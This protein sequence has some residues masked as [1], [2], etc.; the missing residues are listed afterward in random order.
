[1]EFAFEADEPFV[2]VCVCAFCADATTP[3]EGFFK[4]ET[5][6][7]SGSRCWEGTF[8]FFEAKYH[9]D[10]ILVSVAFASGGEDSVSL[11]DVPAEWTTCETGQE[12]VDRQ[13][14]MLRR[15][16]VEQVRWYRDNLMPLYILNPNDRRIAAVI[17]EADR[18]IAERGASEQLRP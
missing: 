3:E 14:A 10:D 15:I 12:Q 6:V 4:K 8:E 18:L 7:S 13:I 1:L 5:T 16:S 9:I 17:A 11:Q 2:T